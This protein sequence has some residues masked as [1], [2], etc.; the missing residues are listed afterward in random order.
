MQEEIARAIVERLRVTI[1]GGAERLVQKTTTNIEAY[2][3]LLK[4][5]V[6]LNRRGPAIVNAIDVSSGRSPSIRTSPMPTRCSGD[7]YRLFGLYGM[8][9]APRSRAAGARVAGARA[10]DRSRSDRGAGDAREHRARL[11][12]ELSRTRPRSPIARW[13]ATRPTCAPSQKAP[14][15]WPRQWPTTRPMRSSNV[16]SNAFGAPARSIR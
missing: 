5:R 4:G 3:L 1:A 10:G 11:R 14:S 16:F 9:P 12:L 8:M 6:F 2:E 15:R 7:T 13:P